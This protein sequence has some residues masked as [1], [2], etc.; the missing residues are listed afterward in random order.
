[1]AQPDLP[2]ELI[3]NIIESLIPSNPPVA[4]SRGD[5]ITRTLLSLTLACKL[6]SREAK[7]LLMKHCLCIDSAQRLDH[8]LRQN[9][10]AVIGSQLPSIGLF[11]SP[12]PAHNLNMPTSVGQINLLS[13]VISKNLTR[14]VIDLPLRHLYPEDD[15]QQ[16]RPILRNAFSRLTKLEEFVSIRGELYLDTVEP[17][18]TPDQEQGS[19]QEPAVWSFW[20][21]LQ[22]LALYNVA[23]DSRQFIEGLRQC[24]NLTHFVLVQPGGLTEGV[25]PERLELDFLPALQRLIIVN[26]GLG[27]VHELPVDG[28]T[29]DES[30]LGR[31]EALRCSAAAGEN[32]DSESVVSF[33]SLRM[34][35]GRDDDEGGI[36]TCQEWLARQATSG[37][38]WTSSDDRGD[39]LDSSESLFEVTYGPPDTVRWESKIS[40]LRADHLQRH[41]TTHRTDKRFLCDFC[42]SLYKRGSKR[43]CSGG[44]PCSE[45]HSREGTCSCDCLRVSTVTIQQNEMWGLLQV[46]ESA[47]DAQLMDHAA[48]DHGPAS[49]PPRS[50]WSLGHQNFYASSGVCYMAYS[51]LQ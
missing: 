44:Q 11:L 49:E 13:T 7:R 33:L 2:A 36:A 34:P 25:S 4:L 45:C 17:Q 22:R 27:F 23:V 50:T 24:S 35:F 28:E 8:L 41:S 26:T 51:R 47:I 16:V 9:T 21:N 40:E 6:V 32:S 39:I 38:L 3:L 31:L 29:W 20:P 46:N 10:L 48:L 42:G 18:G 43:S 37:T 5:V 30:F 12:F 1:M 14:L 15:V 19:N